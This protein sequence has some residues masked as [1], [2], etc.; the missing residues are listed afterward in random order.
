MLWEIWAR[1]EPWTEIDADGIE[2]WQILSDAVVS[3]QR[4]QPPAGC[5]AA[6]EGYLTLMRS[7]WHKEPLQ[8]PKFDVI[9]KRLV[10]LA[11]TLPT[12][13]VQSLQR[14]IYEDEM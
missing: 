14:K 3:G 1:V 13:G 7:C 9:V 2:F 8:R 5:D 11:D 6:P 4:P 12:S 10:D